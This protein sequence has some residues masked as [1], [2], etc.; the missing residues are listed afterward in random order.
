[1]DRITQWPA[2]GLV[3]HDGVPPFATHEPEAHLP[4][5]HDTGEYPTA[6][7]KMGVKQGLPKLRHIFMYQNSSLP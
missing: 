3:V 6:M 2:F 7:A 1:M 5:V 4:A